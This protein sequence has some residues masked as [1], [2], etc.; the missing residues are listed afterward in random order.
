MAVKIERLRDGIEKNVPGA[1]QDRLGMTVTELNG[2]LAAQMGIKET[3]GVVVTA[4]K[5]DGVAAEA[6]IAVGDVIMEI[7]GSKIQT[8]DDFAKAVSA[9]KKGAVMRL[10]LRRGDSALFVAIPVE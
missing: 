8:N 7:N 9:H 1:D 3:K 10:L 6:G 2:E 5:Q 4:V